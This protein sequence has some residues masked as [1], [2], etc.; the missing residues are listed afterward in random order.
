MPNPYTPGIDLVSR[1]AI[2]ALTIVPFSTGQFAYACRTHRTAATYGD[3]L[4]V[5]TW[6]FRVVTES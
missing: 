5:W 2:G 3:V 6:S 4:D 1:S